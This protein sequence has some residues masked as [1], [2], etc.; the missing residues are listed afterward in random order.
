M[1]HD[2]FLAK[3]PAAARGPG[4][5]PGRFADRADAGRR[6]AEQVARLDL[7]DPVVLGLSR[8][9]V[10]IAREIADRLG[11]AAD[12][13]V[14]RKIAV[15]GIPEL[16]IAAIAEGLD[17]VVLGPQAA[18]LGLDGARLAALAGPERRELERRIAVYR[19]GRALP[20]L[21][22]RD[23]V[24][25]DDGLATGVTARAALRALRNRGPRRLV[26]AAPVCA[27]QAAADLAP[28]ADAFVSILTPRR[29]QAVSQW[30]ADFGQLRDA[31]VVALLT[32]AR[33][34]P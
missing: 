19:G 9:G 7:S 24:V 25:A 14:A 10:P 26:L 34:G 28:L 11:V 20:D 22:G 23:V 3:T 18:R 12:V 17:E 33:P 2:W 30:Y 8:G 4:R 15:P 6:L 31:D 29:F 13:F 27:P 1:Q 16:G 21:A 32:T 5:T